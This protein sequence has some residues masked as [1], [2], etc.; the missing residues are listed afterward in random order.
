VV[1]TRPLPPRCFLRVGASLCGG[2]AYAWL[3]RVVRAW[4]AE[5]GLEVSEDAVYERL[6]ALVAASPKTEGLWVRTT[7]LG[8]RGNPAVRG[9][10]IEGINLENLR[11]GP[12]ARATLAGIVEELYGLYR[13]H[14]S[15]TA[16]HRQVVASGGLVQ[17]NPL[18]PTLMEERFGL[19]VRVPPYRESAAVGAVLAAR[20]AG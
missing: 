18:L 5:F 20:T 16:G 12:L 9:G 14:A 3:N 10:A 6:N 2:A 19:A 17:R 7:F 11:L 13:A 8:V 1:E 4:L 15:E